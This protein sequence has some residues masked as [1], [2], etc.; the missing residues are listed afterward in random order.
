MPL[1]FG[2]LFLSAAPS[3]AFFRV[4]ESPIE[5]T[6]TRPVGRMYML[7]NSTLWVASQPRPRVLLRAGF[8]CGACHQLRRPYRC[9]RRAV[10]RFD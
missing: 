9:G 4:P 10:R 5:L 3:G 6:A 7:D 8:F 1:H 2:S